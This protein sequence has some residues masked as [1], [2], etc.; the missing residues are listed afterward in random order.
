VTRDEIYALGK[1]NYVLLLQEA[2][3]EVKSLA[4]AKETE[5]ERKQ[6]RRKLLLAAIREK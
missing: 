6:Y 3:N 4:N 5:N 1:E 2:A